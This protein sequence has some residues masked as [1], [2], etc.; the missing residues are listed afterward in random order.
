MRRP[1]QLVRVNNRGVPMG[2]ILASS[3]VGFL[4]VIAAAVSPDTVFLFLLNSSGAIIL[5]VYLMICISQIIL[6][7]RT[8]P[9][10]LRVKMWLFPV[11]SVLTAAAIV[12]VL[13]QMAFERGH[14]QPAPAEPPRVGGRDRAVPD[15]EVAR[16]I[17]RACGGTGAD[18]EPVRGLDA[19]RFSDLRS[20]RRRR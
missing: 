8:D 12:A 14:A 3:V 9:A 17:G 15:H 6:R 18:A 7:R 4:C 5:F 16:R 20:R 11:L 2:A 13:V 1:R 19:C 10:E